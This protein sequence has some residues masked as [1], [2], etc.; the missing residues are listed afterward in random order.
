MTSVLVLTSPDVETVVLLGD[1]SE[2]DQ[3]AFLLESIEPKLKTLIEKSRFLSAKNKIKH[4]QVLS[5]HI[6]ILDAM[7]EAVTKRA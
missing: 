4:K 2:K 1:L 3:V 6:N 7:L 5:V